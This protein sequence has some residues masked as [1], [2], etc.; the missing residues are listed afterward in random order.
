MKM[1]RENAI[2]LFSSLLFILFLIQIIAP[3]MMNA[4]NQINSNTNNGNQ[5]KI[6]QAIYSGPLELVNIQETITITNP[7]KELTEIVNKIKKNFSIIY[8]EED[9][10]GYSIIL[11]N[12]KDVK[13]FIQNIPSKYQVTLL[14]SLMVKNGSQFLAS[15]KIIKL[16]KDMVIQTYLDRDYVPLQDNNITYTL[17][18][19]LLSESSEIVQV[20]SLKPDETTEYREISFEII[21][22]KTLSIN[23]IDQNSTLYN[24]LIA[25]AKKYNLS[26]STSS[27][28][29]TLKLSINNYNI[30]QLFIKMLENYNNSIHDIKA[31]ANLEIISDN[32]TYEVVLRE[33]KLELLKS[34]NLT[35]NVT[36]I[37]QGNKISSISIK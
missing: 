36:L 35:K 14:V 5:N 12:N 9:Q 17:E 33:I 26:Y 16:D 7:D 3:L 24:D 30:T 28:T 32:K 34:P 10:N 29:D 2:I 20:I 13:N 31:T 1:T 6:V 15:D 21:N 4:T 8:A 11:K 22:I 25:F 18:A 27:Q 37:K 19:Y 23:N